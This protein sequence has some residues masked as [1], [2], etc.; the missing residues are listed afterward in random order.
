MFQGQMGSTQCAGA[1]VPEMMNMRSTALVFDGL[2]REVAR[3]IVS[4]RGPI[5]LYLEIVILYKNSYSDD[6]GSEA[7]MECRKFRAS[8]LTFILLNFIN[9][10][11]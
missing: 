8:L 11:H 2:G 9:L 7:Y 6:R 5:F 4:K 1:L 10:I 3:K